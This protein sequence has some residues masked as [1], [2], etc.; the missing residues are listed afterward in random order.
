MDSWLNWNKFKSFI[1]ISLFV[2]NLISKAIFSECKDFYLQLCFLEKGKNTQN[3]SHFENENTFRKRITFWKWKLI[4]KPILKMKT[5]FWSSYIM[6]EHDLIL[7]D[8][9]CILYCIGIIYNVAKWVRFRSL[10]VKGVIQN[11]VRIVILE[12]TLVVFLL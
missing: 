10:E 1:Y 3:L 9:E 7:D 4:P 11:V 2:H 12:R 5:C 6:S 8:S